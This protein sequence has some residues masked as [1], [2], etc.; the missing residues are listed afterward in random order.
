MTLLR[1]NRIIALWIII[2]VAVLFVFSLQ[3]SAEEHHGT[4]NVKNESSRTIYIVLDDYNQGE[5][6]ANYSHEYKVTMG[7]HKVEA[8]SGD[9]KI[10]KYITVSRSYPDA[11]WCIT[12]NDF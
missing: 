5:I 6:W 7:E 12:N 3:L 2:S 11:E 9:D 10:S 8:Y 4:I 1:R